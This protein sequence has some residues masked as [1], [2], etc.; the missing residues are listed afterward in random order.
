LQASLKNL[1][2]EISKVGLMGQGVGVDGAGNIYFVPGAIPGDRVRVR[3]EETSK[4]YRDAELIEVVRA[5]EERTSPQ[6]AYF[7]KCGGCDWLH[8]DYGAQLK[9]KEASIRHV[10][11]RGTLTPEKFLPIQASPKIW[12]YRNRVQLRKEGSSVGFYRKR[13][14]DIV[15]IESCAVAHPAINQALSSLRSEPSSFRT[16]IEL[17][18][19][20]E[21]GV[22]R[23]DNRAHSAS[24]FRQIN[25]EQNQYL[26]SRVAHYI[27]EAKTKGVLELFCGDG[28][29]SLAYLPLVEEMIGIDS[30]SA[31]IDLARARKE[32]IAPAARAA[33]FCDTVDRRLWAKL[34]REFQGN[35]DTLV[36]DPPRDGLE[37][38]MESL[39]RP[40]IKRVIYISCSPVTF[41]QDVQ[42]L[43]KEFAFRELQPVDMFPHTKHIE[44][45]AYFER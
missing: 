20:A 13:S 45:I 37:G 39:I 38:A 24:G 17:Q 21:G 34:P 25:D 41:S 31:A 40:G 15:D 26:Q 18:V 29:F 10:L 36:V 7:Q 30:N 43:K 33:F 3:H 16:K 23:L 1:E 14:H 4:K 5:S 42:C 35:C 19:N 9:A 8:W 32:T 11:E 44:L 27:R 12:G 28:N 22:E 6:C 2:V